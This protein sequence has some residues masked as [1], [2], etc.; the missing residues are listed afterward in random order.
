[1]SVENILAQFREVAS[2]P[3]KQLDKYLAEGKK[4]VAVA[5]VYT[6]E[7]IIHSMGIVPMGVWG[8]DKELQGSKKYFPAFICSIVQ[9]I[10]DLGIDG[11]YK[12][13]SALVVPYF[14]DSLKILGENWKYAVPNIPFIPMAYPQNRL[15]EAG[16]AFTKA[17][18]K[19]LI[20]DLEKITEARFDENALASSI[21]I[22]NEHNKTM[23]R[24]SEILISC[25]S[26]GA[27]ERS[28]IYKSAYFMTKEEHT[29]LVKQLISEI[30]E[31]PVQETTKARVLTIGILADNPSLLSFFDDNGMQ[32]VADD[33]AHE[34]RQYRIDSPQASSPLESL[35][36]KFSA[37]GNCS[38]LHDPE[39][40][41][42]DY[43]VEQVM[44]TRA[45]GVI[46]LMTKFC[47][48]EEFEY[49][50]IKKACD[51]AKIPVI[52]I[53][54]DRQMVNYEQ[55]RTILEAFKDIIQTQSA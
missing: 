24:L 34:S 11:S 1:M 44:R 3:R 36:Q 15:N 48:P 18:Y 8:A 22:Y 20:E 55:A 37:M 19:K 39:N 28:N 42:P 54:V 38:V 41:H 2:S 17:G 6:P 13:V 51:K 53:E 4:V 9:S 40:T 30:E 26:I 23:R 52:L 21:E 33:V 45:E 43:V 5:P 49:V 31:T 16:I 47:D 7:E 25:S 10:T 29:V 32:I 50:R 12:G 35:A 14:C 46:V 27:V